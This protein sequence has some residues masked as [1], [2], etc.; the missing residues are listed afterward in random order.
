M[1]LG[2]PQLEVLREVALEKTGSLEKFAEKCAETGKVMKH[3][4]YW[5]YAKTILN[6][7]ERK[8]RALAPRPAR[9]MYQVLDQ[10]KRVSFLGEIGDQPLAG[11]LNKTARRFSGIITYNKFKSSH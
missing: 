10:D 11:E 8:R 5:M 7:F 9:A 6:Y 2:K 4:S 1:K 3:P